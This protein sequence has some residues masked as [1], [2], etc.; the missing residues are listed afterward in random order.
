MKQVIYKSLCFQ[1]TAVGT[2]LFLMR[3]CDKNCLLALFQ[4]IALIIYLAGRIK[5][6][7]PFMILCP[8]SVF[9]KWKEEMEKYRVD[10]AG[11]VLFMLI[12]F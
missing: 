4:T 12:F 5:D 11:L 8:L 2:L 10:V 7:G 3:K 6:E 9:N 1:L